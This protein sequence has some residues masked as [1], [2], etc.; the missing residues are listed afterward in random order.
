MKKSQP[1]GRESESIAE[2]GAVDIAV[3]CSCFENR[4]NI[5]RKK[6]QRQ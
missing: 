6:T 4:V 3:G 2:E 1:Q 5:D